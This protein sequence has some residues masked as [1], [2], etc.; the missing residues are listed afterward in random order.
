MN[1]NFLF[2]D[3]EVSDSQLNQKKAIHNQ[4]KL[5]INTKQGNV[6]RKKPKEIN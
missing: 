1:F 3:T 6:Q 2:S 5:M 4:T